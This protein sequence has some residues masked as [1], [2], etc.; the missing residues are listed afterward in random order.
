MAS[1]FM[2]TARISGDED[3]PAGINLGKLTK[4]TLFAGVDSS[5]VATAVDPA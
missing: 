3:K 4:Y 2:T 5:A 1:K